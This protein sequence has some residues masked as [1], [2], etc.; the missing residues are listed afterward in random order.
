MRRSSNSDVHYAAAVPAFKAVW[1]RYAKAWTTRPYITVVCDKYILETMTTAL[2]RN[3]RPLQE[4]PSANPMLWRCQHEYPQ[5]LQAA[6]T[7]MLFERFFI[8][9]CLLYLFG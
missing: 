8:C 4:S 3:S 7:F 6:V 5:P 2:E 1:C 9:T